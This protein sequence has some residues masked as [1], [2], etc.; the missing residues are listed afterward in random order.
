LRPVLFSQAVHEELD[1]A[2]ARAGVDIE[3]LALD[4]QLSDLPKDSPVGALVKAFRA[5]VLESCI[6]AGT[7]ER[8]DV[9]V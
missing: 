5:K 6:A 4:E 9:T 1:S 8:L 7:D 2:A 3:A